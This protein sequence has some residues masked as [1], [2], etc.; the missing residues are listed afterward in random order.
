MGLYAGMNYDAK[1]RAEI[2]NGTLDNGPHGDVLYGGYT[3]YCAP[4]ATKDSLYGNLGMDTLYGGGGNDLLIAAA[5]AGPS[6]VPNPNQPATGSNSVLYGGYGNDSLY[7]GGGNDSLLAGKGNDW[8]D[9]RGGTDTL[10]GG[11][12]DDTFALSVS[13]AYESTGSSGG[14][15]G[16]SI[17]QTHRSWPGDPPYAINQYTNTLFILG[18]Q[19][20]GSLQ[21]PTNFND[22]ITVQETGAAPSDAPG[23]LHTD[24]EVNYDA[25]Y[26]VPLGASIPSGAVKNNG[27]IIVQWRDLT[28][29]APLF[30]QIKVVG[31]GGGDYIY[32]AHGNDP[33][34]LQL[35]DPANPTLNYGPASAGDDPLNLVKDGDFVAWIEGGADGNT[36]VGPDGPDQIFGGPGD[37]LIYGGE[38]YSSTLWGDSIGSSSS[39]SAGTA[40]DTLFGGGSSDLIA[41]STSDGSELFAWSEDPNPV[42]T[43]LHFQNRSTRLSTPDVPNGV[44]TI[45]ASRASPAR[46]GRLTLV[47]RCHIHAGDRLGQF[48]KRDGALGADGQPCGSRRHSGRSKRRR[49]C[50]ATERCTGHCGTWRHDCRWRCSRSKRR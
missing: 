26:T 21:T 24:L 43:Q 47:R 41:P 30:Q 27:Q 38:G 34:A 22:V 33:G 6:Y 7:G 9:G 1:L 5:V 4:T 20:P 37:N 48:R 19:G 32:F 39:Q 49:S 3:E 36:L 44:P 35:V 2:N 40:R 12:G 8:L 16:E 10:V 28:T 13:A 23:I 42:I 17:N 18:G 46:S 50:A 31:G 25:N 14:L 29:G 11:D 15:Y 45:T